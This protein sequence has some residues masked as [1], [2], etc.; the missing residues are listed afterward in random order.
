[1]KGG[2]LEDKSLPLGKEEFEGNS[3]PLGR[4]KA[5]K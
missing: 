1:M 2:F 5:D 4:V 3:L